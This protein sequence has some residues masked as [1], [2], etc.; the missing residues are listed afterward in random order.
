MLGI[1]MPPRQKFLST[2]LPIGALLFSF[3]VG[4]ESMP[5]LTIV[6]DDILPQEVVPTKMAV[7]GKSGKTG[8]IKAEHL[9][10]LKTAALAQIWQ[11][12]ATTAAKV[13][14]R[15]CTSQIVHWQRSCGEMGYPESFA[16]NVQGVTKVDCGAQARQERWL[17]NSCAPV[18][19]QATVETIAAEATEI[20]APVPE[21]AAISLV[22]APAPI[23][24]LV[25]PPAA[26]V[27][28]TVAA[29]VIAVACGAAAT[30]LHS[31]QPETDLCAGGVAENLVGNGPWQ[32]SCRGSAGGVS[33]TCFAPLDFAAVAARQAQDT[34]A[35]PAVMSAPSLPLVQEV[36]AQQI[37]EPQIVPEVEPEPQ[38][39]LTTP[40]LVTPSLT[41]TVATQSAPLATAALATPRLDMVLRSNRV[42]PGSTDYAPAAPIRAAATLYPSSASSVAIVPP[43]MKMLAFAVGMDAPEE[44]IMA[45]LETLGQKLAVNRLARVTVTAYAGMGDGVDAR[46]ARKLSLARAMVVRDALMMG[47]ATSDQVRMRA[48][49]ANVAAGTPERVD[50]TDN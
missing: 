3:P 8:R 6:A 19:A 35:I 12:T 14:V 11:V 23:A 1:T 31:S 16:G 20:A 13:P 44:A 5:P 37:T 47:G 2:A 28:Q 29:P 15:V 10:S 42:Q 22:A 32:W 7:L 26:A 17:A 9:A 49:G 39:T 41:T 4:A 45:Q 36:R 33:A 50:L 43:E 38:L 46:A 25:V 34:V 30:S 18:I 21:P 24:P 27:P 40:Q 48:L